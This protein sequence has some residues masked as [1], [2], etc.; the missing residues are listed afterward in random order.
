MAADCNGL[1]AAQRDL[2]TLENFQRGR[3]SSYTVQ[4][5][6]TGRTLNDGVAVWSY[7]NTGL[8]LQDNC[9]SRRGSA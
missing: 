9:A 5:L 6:Q 1:S 3:I 2:A 7:T 4:L 8:F